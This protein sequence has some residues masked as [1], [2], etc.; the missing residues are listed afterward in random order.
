M[1]F[2][3]AKEHIEQYPRVFVGDEVY[4]RAEKIYARSPVTDEEVEVEYDLPED[5]L[6]DV[7]RHIDVDVVE[8]LLKG[9]KLAHISVEVFVYNERYGLAIRAMSI[10]EATAA[11][12]ASCLTS[13]EEQEEEL[14]DGEVGVSE[15][16][17]GPTV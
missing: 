6:E 8:P 1:P 13:A 2:V 11:I 15:G 9:R 10:G 7:R 12:V 3:L 14:E 17:E 5:L 4:E 16:E